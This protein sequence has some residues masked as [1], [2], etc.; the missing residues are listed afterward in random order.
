MSNASKIVVR[1]YIIFSIMF[2]G[3]VA[4]LHHSYEKEEMFTPLEYIF[5]G[6]MWPVC[7]TMMTINSITGFPLEMNK[8]V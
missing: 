2:A 4:S 5:L 3:T 7:G 6:F 1:M 8:D